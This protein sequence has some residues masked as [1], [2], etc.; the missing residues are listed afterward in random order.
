MNDDDQQLAGIAHWIRDELGELTPWHIT[1]F[2]PNHHMA[3]IPP[4]PVS[5]LEHA[6]D[7]GRKAGLKFIYTGNVPGHRDENTVCLSCGRLIVQRCGYQTKVI[8]LE[9]SRCP[10]C[11]AELNFRTSPPGGGHHD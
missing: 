7:I 2:Y 8:G 1:R 4:T 9:D 11:G 5:T 3:D 10:S 6:Y